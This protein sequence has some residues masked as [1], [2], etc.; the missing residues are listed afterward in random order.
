MNKIFIAIIFSVIPLLL[1]AE[2]CRLTSQ[3][4]Q[5]NLKLDWKEFDQTQNMGHRLLAAKGCYLEAA[6]LTDSYNLQNRDLIDPSKLRILYFHA[7]Q[8]YAYAELNEVAVSRMMNSLNPKE[9]MN[10]E[11][12]WNDYVQ[13]SVAFLRNDRE[14]LEIFQKK[15]AA[16]KASEGNDLNLSVVNNFLKCLGKPYSWP[17]GRSGDCK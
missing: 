7:G 11:L 17:Y 13:A 14:S 10:P 6:L 12:N 15:L 9:D 16:G 2:E 5:D 3:Q 8:M 1:S 4:I